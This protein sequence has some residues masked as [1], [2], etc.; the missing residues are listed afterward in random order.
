MHTVLALVC[1]PDDMEFFCSGTLLACKSRGDRVVVCN[2]CN[3]DLGSMEIPP[4]KL[5]EI[6]LREAEASCLIGG[7]EHLPPLFS[8]LQIYWENKEAVKKVAK[9]IRDWNPDFIITHSCNDYMADHVAVSK[10][11]SIAAGAACNP[12]FCPEM[13]EVADPMPIYCMQPEV[14]LG[15]QAN[16]YVDT[17][18]YM[19][20]RVEM[21]MCHKSQYEWLAEHDNVD[22]TDE[23]KTMSRYMGFQAGCLYAEGFNLSSQSPKHPFKRILP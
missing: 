3:G 22:C 13:G 21:L 12:S 1:H 11:V 23:I 14:G 10:L 20:K 5:S 8:D 16:E 19:E 17:S 9:I 15:F 7:F 6:R 2:L 18:D 4:K